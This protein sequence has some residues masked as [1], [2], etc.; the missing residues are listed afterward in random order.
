MNTVLSLVI[1]FGKPPAG[2]KNL[3]CIFDVIL[4]QNLYFGT[5]LVHFEVY[6][7]QMMYGT[8]NSVQYNQYTGIMHNI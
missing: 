6:R 4:V 2:A 7:Y 5:K 1:L 3:T 8:S